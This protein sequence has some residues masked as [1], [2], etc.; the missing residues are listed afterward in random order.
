ML[1]NN[2]DTSDWRFL[3]VDFALEASQ[4][5]EKCPCSNIIPPWFYRAC[6]YRWGGLVP[7]SPRMHILSVPHVLSFSFPLLFFQ[8]MSTCLL[9]FFSCWP[10]SQF[11]LSFSRPSMLAC[12]LHHPPLTHVM[13]S[14]HWTLNQVYAWKVIIL[15]LLYCSRFGITS[16]CPFTF[17]MHS[18]FRPGSFI[19]TSSRPLT[20]HI[21]CTSPLSECAHSLII[22]AIARASN[23]FSHLIS[24]YLCYA[25][26]PANKLLCGTPR[27]QQIDANFYK[28]CRF[29]LIF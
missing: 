3:F 10:R 24:F 12:F 23:S 25:P 8:V 14:S 11:A 15:H 22:V 27:T 28:N 6:N 7:G 29:P 4:V 18:R 2:D 1:I 16:L 9:Q 13:T 21:K 5:C 20:V 19:N 26:G 17:S